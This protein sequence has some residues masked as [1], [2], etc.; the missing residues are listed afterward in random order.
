MGASIFDFR[1]IITDF[2]IGVFTS[3]VTNTL[4]W[5][6]EAGDQQSG[7]MAPQH[8]LVYYCRGSLRSGC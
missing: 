5:Q 8:R 3:A 4:A 7:P 1:I 6:P 2:V